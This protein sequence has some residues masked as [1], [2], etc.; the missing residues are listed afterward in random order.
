MKPSQRVQLIKAIAL[1]LS[2]EPRATVDLT[3]R[4]FGF[5]TSERWQGDTHDYIIHFAEQGPDD[6]LV[7][8]GEHL[9]IASLSPA[10][11]SEPSFWQQGHFRLFLSHVSTH[12]GAVSQLRDHL[13][14]LL[15]SGFVAHN[16]IEPTRE[17]QNE[18]ERALLT[19]DAL[20]AWITP[21]FHAS[22][23]TDQ[24]VGAAL[25][26]GLL[27]LPLKHGAVPYGFIGKYQ[28]LPV[29]QRQ[30]S[31]LASDIFGHLAKHPLSRTRLAECVVTS[32]ETAWSWE[33]VRRD[34]GLLERFPFLDQ[35]HLDR[36]EA[37][38]AASEKI[39]DTFGMVARVGQFITKMRSAS[40]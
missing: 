13:G 19:A 10:P 39:R 17:W 9:G 12:K 5:G 21:D 18:I 8:L 28:A 7:E 32:F 26:R 36:L 33:N 20:A 4:Q 34:M 1:R 38:T 31:D 37:A 35:Y 25:G 3:M 30:P 2:K 24:E 16:D 29:A 27:V 6:K 14:R 11:A 23:W 40:A 15:I 22:N